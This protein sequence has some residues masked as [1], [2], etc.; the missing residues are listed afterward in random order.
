MPTVRAVPISYADVQSEAGRG[1][2]ADDDVLCAMLA[3]P[4]L[5]LAQIAQACGWYFGDGEPAISK[6]QKALERLGNFKLAKKR[7]RGKW[8]LTEFGKQEARKTAIQR[9]HNSSSTV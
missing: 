1:D 5:S 9:E 2:D 3:K 8:Q 6:V 7:R 4:D